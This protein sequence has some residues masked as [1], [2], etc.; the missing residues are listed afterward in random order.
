MNENWGCVVFIGGKSLRMG[1]RDKALLKLGN[2][3]LLDITVDRME[4]SFSEVVLSVGARRRPRESLNQLIDVTIRGNEIGPIGG[5]LSAIHWAE[6]IG[7]DGL[8]TVPVDT[9][10]IRNDLFNFLVQ[11]NRSTYPVQ[12]KRSH[13]LHA[14]W[15]RQLFSRI[16]HAVEDENCRSIRSLHENL[17]S[18]AIDIPKIHDHEFE[19]INTLGK[20]EKLNLSLLD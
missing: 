15:P 4:L 2:Q 12:N 20:L 8:A 13:W 19:N 14:A 16:R 5:I 7:L 11:N 18:V 9:P 17:G 6:K 1:G 3:R 10:V